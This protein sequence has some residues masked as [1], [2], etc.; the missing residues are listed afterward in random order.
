ML[1]TIQCKGELIDLST[2]KVM[3][4]L[5]ITPDS[6]FDGGKYNHTDSIVTQC[7]KM[8]EEGATFVDIGGYSSRPGAANISETEEADRLLPAIEA[9]V[10]A[11]PNVLLSVDTFRSK[12]AK[13]CIEQG[14]ALINDIAAGELDNQMLAT[15]AQLQVPYILMHMKGNPQNMQ[16]QSAYQNITKEV[17]FYLSEKVALA[18]SYGINDIII[19]PGFG[20]A[21][22]LEQNY[23]LMKELSVLQFHNLPIL[24]GISR[25]SMLYKLLDTTPDKALNGTTVLNTIALQNGASILRVHDVKEATECIAIVK[26]LNA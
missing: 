23:K 21:K 20:F 18:K 13:A 14:A 7:G 17:N 19:D 25:K 5:N 24:V 15:V 6:F 3:G 22:T 2:P 8:L 16:Q 4:I 1:M 12:V 10:K 9:I 11:F 26:Q